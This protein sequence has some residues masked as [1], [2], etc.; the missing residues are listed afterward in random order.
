LG[1]QFSNLKN[2]A[3]DALI[4]IRGNANAWRLPL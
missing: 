2:A 4:T 3:S 1:W